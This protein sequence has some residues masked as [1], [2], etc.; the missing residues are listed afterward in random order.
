VGSRQH[1]ARSREMVGLVTMAGWPMHGG[2]AV[3]SR[4]D[5]AAVRKD[6]DGVLRAALPHACLR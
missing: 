6:D 3:C 1:V 2:P 4:Q 5:H